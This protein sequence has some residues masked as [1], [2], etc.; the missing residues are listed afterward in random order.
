[1]G[2]SRRG[3]GSDRRNANGPADAL[4]ADAGAP[5][6]WAPIETALSCERRRPALQRLYRQADTAHFLPSG[7]HRP[8]QA[9]SSLFARP[10]SAARPGQA[11]ACKDVQVEMEDLLARLGAAVE[12][13]AIVRVP[14]L[15]DDIASDQEE[16]PHEGEIL[17]LQL[18]ERWNRFPRDHQQMDRRTRVDIANNDALVILVHEVPG[19]L[20]VH[21]FL[22]EGLLVGHGPSQPGVSVRVPP[23]ELQAPARK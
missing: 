23:Q 1:M 15:V 14:E 5:P 21:D 18:I 4:E 2:C 17:R 3:V 6:A 13:G 12:D 16:V 7:R 8:S 19:D 10:F 20:P 11:A 9:V 22:E